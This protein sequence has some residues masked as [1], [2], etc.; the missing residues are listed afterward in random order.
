MVK[1]RLPRIKQCSHTNCSAL[2]IG[3]DGMCMSHSTRTNGGAW[4]V[5]DV[6]GI[7]NPIG[8]ELEC[9][10][11]NYDVRRLTEC[12]TGDG[13]LPQGGHEIK[14][15]ADADKVGIVAGDIARKAKMLGATVVRQCGFHVHTSLPQGMT[16]SYGEDLSRETKS[17]IADL[18]VAIQD[19]AFSLFPSRLENNYC[20]K[21]STNNYYASSRMQAHYDWCS[22]SGHIPTIEVRLHTGTLSPSKIYAWGKVCTG[23][24]KIF[25]DL[26]AGKET[27]AIKRARNGE[28][29]RIFRKNSAAREYLE[30]RKA[31]DGRNV[32]FRMERV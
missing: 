18:V 28:F 14:I 29:I 7:K 5:T 30:A 20:R 2:G 6:S 24:Q 12:V 8:M 16:R 11:H 32:R 19:E 4:T 9:V 23:L 27:P 1:L 31:A 21:I 15:L 10:C 26:I 17:K 13:S 25:H 3:M 22:F